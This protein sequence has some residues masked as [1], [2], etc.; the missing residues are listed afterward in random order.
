[1]PAPACAC[2]LF[3]G[4]CLRGY[5]NP[6]FSGKKIRPDFVPPLPSSRPPRGVWLDLTP[7]GAGK[8]PMHECMP[9]ACSQQQILRT[10]DFWQL[11][12]AAQQQVPGP[13][14]QLLDFLAHHPYW[15]LL[16]GATRRRRPP[17]P[18]DPA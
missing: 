5:A 15:L 14:V 8:R 18:P 4:Q 16:A 13:S 12:R 1:M 3:R 17:A 2:G 11:S 6:L 10:I 9:P 7:P